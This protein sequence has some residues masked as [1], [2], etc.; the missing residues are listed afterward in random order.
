M[1][2]YP[3]FRLAIFLAAGIFFA[4]TCRAEMGIAPL[5]VLFLLPL[6]LGVGLNR[7]SYERRWLFGAGVSAFMFLLGWFLTARAWKE[8]VVDW[9]SEYQVYRGV[10]QESF[11][12]KPKT[13]RFRAEVSGKEVFL[14]LPKDSLSASVGIGDELLLYARIEPPKNRDGLNDFDYA[15]Y[16]YREGI[17]GTAYVPASAWR[18]IGVSAR[19]TWKQKALVCREWVIRKYKECGIGEKQLPVLSALTLGYK[20]YLDAE[21]RQAYSKAGI[22]HVLALS[23]MHIG[24]VWLLLDGVLKVLLVA[25]LRW[26]RGGLVSLV[27]WAFAFVVGLEPSVVRAV[28]MCMLMELGRLSGTK[29]LSL[30]T[31]SIAAFFMLLYRPFYL[32]DVGFQLSFVAVASI[33]YL[34]PLIFGCLSVRNRIGRWMWGVTSVSVSAQLGTAPL[35]MYYFSNFSVYFLLANLLVAILLPLIILG[36]ALLLLTVPLSGMQAVVAQVL[37]RLVAGMN[38]I[39]SWVSDLPGAS[40]S[41]SGVQVMEVV[42]YYVVLAMGIV[43]WKTRGKRWLIRLLSALVCLLAFHL[44]GLLGF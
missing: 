37:D 4:E 30:N 33:L 1:K 20:D 13:Y 29:A 7:F 26:L 21:T 17:S 15:R 6:A 43:Y 8:V 28:I 41:L 18:R 24:I 5:A 42:L 2:T 44:A 9:P 23:G 35:V 12:E 25:R 27:L 36:S 14:Y 16:L 32:F 19:L 11:V 38:G 22:S 40:F 3:I 39:A 34:Y 10:V 31:L